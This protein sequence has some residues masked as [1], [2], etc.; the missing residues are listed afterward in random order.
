M[1]CTGGARRLDQDGDVRAHLDTGGLVDLVTVGSAQQVGVA[2]E[3]A[4]RERAHAGQAAHHPGKRLGVFDHPTGLLGREGGVGDCYQR[5]DRGMDGEAKRHALRGHQDQPPVDRRCHLLGVALHVGR[6]SEHPVGRRLAFRCQQTGG[7]P[8]HQGGG[9]RSETLPDGDRVVDRQFQRVVRDPA[10]RLENSVAFGL[11]GGEAADVVHRP[12]RGGVRLDDA[13][14]GQGHSQAVVSGSQVGGTGRG[15]NGRF[16]DSEPIG[17]SVG[18]VGDLFDIDQLLP[19]MLLA[20][21]LAMIV[22]NALAWFKYR[23]GQTPKGVGEAQFRPGRA[24]WM[25]VVGT[26]LSLWAGISLLT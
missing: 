4:G 25:L 9:R 12:V 23:R 1:E 5:S 13:A 20:V 15:G 6:E 11:G 8:G 10:S 3:Q 24:V 2:G 16:H 19:Q 26:I 17:S 22:G 21:G 7:N 18:G 14:Q